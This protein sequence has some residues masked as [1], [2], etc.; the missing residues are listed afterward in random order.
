M[1][2]INNFI[3][4]FSEVW[5]KGIFGIN[6]T[7][8]IIGF[9]IFLAFYVLRRLFARFIIGRLNKIVLKSKTTIDDTVV[10]VIEGPLKFLPVVI[11]FFIASSYIDLKSDIQIF[12]DLVNRTLITIFIFWLLHQLIVPFA[13]L[14][15]SFEEK[16]TTAL[17]EWT[18][19]GLK[20]IVIILGVV[21]ILE[22]WG[23]KVGPVIAGLGLF[24]VA[25]ALGAQDL[26]KNLISGIMILM[27]RR[28]QIGDVININGE[29][30]GT[31]EQIG[32][33]ST[34][35]RQFDSNAVTVPNF[36]FAEQSVIN[37]SRRIHRRIRWVIGLEY[38]TSIEQLKNIR[39]QIKKFIDEDSSFANDGESYYKSSFVRIENFSD[40]SI[41]MLVE[42]FTKTSE[43]KKFIEVKENLA[44]KIKEIVEAEK[45]GFAF[46]SQSIYVE[47]I[48]KDN[49]EIFNLRNDKQ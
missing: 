8:I 15:K 42:C 29:A 16:L 36:K 19:K 12:I 13:F 6:A 44:I 10:E 30:E 37:H 18:L 48:S 17:V 49:P 23:I 26:F 21:A 31:V 43:W 41:D 11:G 22:L 7:E 40:S 28:F 32:F 27:E 1:S 2:S 25:V 9:A 47:S 4:L 38:K 20:I 14:I 24:G 3:S 45:A 46:P 35:I 34:L 33:R 39:N 5:Q